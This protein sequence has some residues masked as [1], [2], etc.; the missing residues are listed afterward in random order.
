MH[1]RFLALAIP[2][3]VLSPL[4]AS[5]QA[6]VPTSTNAARAYHHF[7][8]SPYSFRT[9]SSL[10]SAYP[11]QRVT[12]Y[13]IE[14]SFVGPVYVHQRITPFGFES[15]TSPPPPNLTVVRYPHRAYYPPPVYV[16]PYPPPG[17]R[18]R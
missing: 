8:T 9:F 2:F 4:T 17:P 3:A 1:F 16:S 14:S 13:G 6:Y 7:L 18:G 10:S 11:V 15:Y 5:A 12:P